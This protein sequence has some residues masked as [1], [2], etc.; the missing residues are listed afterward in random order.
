MIRSHIRRTQ[1]GAIFVEAIIV[2]SFFTLCFL[3]VLYFRELYVAKM[4]VQRLARASAMAHA[5]SACK[6]D[7]RAGL[8]QDLPAPPT[9]TTAPGTG[10]SA[11]IEVPGGGKGARK[12]NDAINALGRSSALD[13][14]T[15]VTLNTTA[16]ATTQKDP[17]SPKQGFESEVSSESFV[18]CMDPVSDEQFG[19]ILPHVLDVFGSIFTDK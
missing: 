15:V 10:R 2:I 3:G 7:A 6:A 9:Q 5:M 4:Q 12:A 8:E 1:R 13:R 17:L 14:V 18:S 11:E 19:Q 16:S